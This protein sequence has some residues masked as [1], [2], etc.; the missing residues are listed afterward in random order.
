MRNIVCPKCGRCTETI[1]TYSAGQPYIYGKC[2]CGY[3]SSKN[4]T[5][6]TTNTSGTNNK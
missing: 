4:Y 1:I 5:Y 2:N 6:T 3:D